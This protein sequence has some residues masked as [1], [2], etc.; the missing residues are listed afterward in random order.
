MAAVAQPSFH[1]EVIKAYRADFAGGVQPLSGVA[2]KRIAEW[3]AS[4]K[5]KAAKDEA[6]V[7]ARLSSAQQRAEGFLQSRKE[8]AAALNKRIEEAASRRAECDAPADLAARLEG[9]LSAAEHAR[10]Q[11]LEARKEAA[12]KQSGKVDAALEAARAKTEGAAARLEGK[13]E[14]AESLR[15]AALEERVTRAGDH[16]AQ[17]RARGMAAFAERTA[18]MDVP[19]EGTAAMDMPATAGSPGMANEH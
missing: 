13:L 14:K 15:K 11:V 17:V 3:E 8:A 18:A 12:A 1:P 4:G 6:E 10:Q 16:V 5:T 2:K 7:V 9:K 19:A